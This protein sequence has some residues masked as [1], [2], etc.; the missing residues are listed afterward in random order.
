MSDLTNAAKLACT[1]IYF[2]INKAAFSK[3][4]QAGETI[5][6]TAIVDGVFHICFQ[7]TANLHG[8]IADFDVLPYRHPTFGNVHSGFYENLPA[9]L[10]FLI[11]DIPAGFKIV[12]SGHSK[13][14]GEGVL[15]A[16][17]LILA[18]FKEVSCILFACP[19]AGE[20]QFAAGCKKT[21]RVYRFV[22]CLK[23]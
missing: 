5:C 1:Y 21:Y 23:N 19:N 18:G 20:K 3:L 14:A 9:I 17:E 22:T 13:G 8:W 2:P 4:Y 12:V 6:G 7:G 10:K 15:C 11:P 16:A